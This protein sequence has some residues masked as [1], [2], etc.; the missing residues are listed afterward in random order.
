MDLQRI[1]KAKLEMK[2][3]R[4]SIERMD[5]WKED[6][7]KAIAEGLVRIIIESG[8]TRGVNSFRLT[9]EQPELVM[10]LDVLTELR[11]QVEEYMEVEEDDAICKFKIIDLSFLGLRTKVVL[12]DFEVIR[13]P[14]KTT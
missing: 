4:E 12:I 13:T 7:T 11:F 6:A 8:G 5:K 10:L 1:Q 2:Q 9:V 3:Q 14:K